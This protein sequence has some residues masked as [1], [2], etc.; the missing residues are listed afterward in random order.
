MYTYY[1]DKI[2]IWIRI[3]ISVTGSEKE[4]IKIW[5]EKKRENYMIQV[6]CKL[7]YYEK[8]YIVLSNKRYR[9]E[10]RPPPPNHPILSAGFR[11][12]GRIR[13]SK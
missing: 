7:F 6:K 13:F 4:T 10:P 5:L 3:R 9:S 11:R 12:Y 8:P 2:F 1:I